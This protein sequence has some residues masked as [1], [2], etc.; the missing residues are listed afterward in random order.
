MPQDAA[1]TSL[2]EE[3][4]AATRQGADV[5]AETQPEIQAGSIDLEMLRLQRPTWMSEE[6]A[7]SCCTLTNHQPP[8]TNHQPPTTNCQPLTTYHPHTACHFYHLLLTIARRVGGEGAGRRRRGGAASV[9]PLGVRRP[10]ASGQ[11]P[12]PGR[13]C[14][15]LQL[16]AFG[17]RQS[18]YIETTDLA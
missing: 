8:T 4:A 16:L 1:V 9:E 15:G 6:Q 18:L 11:C 12:S 7:A 5:P 2:Q 14:G 13:Q 3:R 10:Q 17:S